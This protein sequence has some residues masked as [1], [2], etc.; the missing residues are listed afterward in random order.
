M[1]Q[2]QQEYSHV[3]VST[4]KGCPFNY[5]TL[6]YVPPSLLAYPLLGPLAW[7]PFWDSAIWPTGDWSRIIFHFI[8]PN[9]PRRRRSKVRTEAALLAGKV[10]QHVA[11]NFS[12]FSYRTQKSHLYIFSTSSVFYVIL[13]G[14]LLLCFSHFL[15]FLFT[16]SLDYIAEGLLTMLTPPPDQINRQLYQNIHQ[17]FRFLWICMIRN[18][19]GHRIPVQSK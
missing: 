11:Y 2:E 5:C 7:P 9:T 10:L 1:Q 15:Y 16:F 4:P 17:C 8:T 14:V 18:A 19:F 13:R 3:L 12:H 6:I